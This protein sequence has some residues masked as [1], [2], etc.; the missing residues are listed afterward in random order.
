MLWSRSTAEARERFLAV[1][2]S[3]DPGTLLRAR[4]LAH[5]LSA[6][7]TASALDRGDQALWREALAERDRA[8]LD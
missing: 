8:L 4:V 2:G 1:Y 5:C 6:M 7:L 3:V